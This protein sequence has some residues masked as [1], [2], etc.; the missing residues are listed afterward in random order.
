MVLSFPPPIWCLFLKFIT[1]EPTYFFF[2]IAN[3]MSE[4]GNINLYLQ[5]ACRI[6]QTTE[7]D[8][9]TPCDD[10]ERGVT[11][12]AT[13]SAY[14]Q[15]VKFF[16]VI[17]CSAFYST[18]SDIAGRKRRLFLLMVPLGKLLESAIQCFHVY[19]WSLPPIYAALTST[20]IQILFGNGVT[21]MIFGYMYLS[22][23]VDSKNRTMRL[24]ILS[25]MRLLGL[26][27][28][29]GV[30]GFLLHS[31]GF[32]RYNAVCF[33]ISLIALIFGFLC[34]KDI[35]VPM[36]KKVMFWSV[37]NLNHFFKSFKIILGR[38]NVKER[39]VKFLLLIC[40]CL[41]IFIHEGKN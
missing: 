10:T 11:V 41:L 27:V 9:E 17:A 21:I 5:K 37:Q 39:I 3:A 22:D 28:G 32:L 24:G 25:S 20:V 29:Q 34:I 35:S 23:T 12:V 7:P 31:A 6:N 33:A 4:F 1:V 16:L 15:P 26:V 14:V 18:W 40:F 30:S 36:E 2:T 8:L 19:W 13:V 38:G